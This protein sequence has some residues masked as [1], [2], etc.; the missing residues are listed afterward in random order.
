MKH[1]RSAVLLLLLLLARSACGTAVL[2]ILGELFQVAFD[3]LL[4][5]GFKVGFLA[6]LLLLLS[7]LI[8]KKDR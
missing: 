2:W 6:T 5:S 3:S 4:Y 1:I 8:K 7:G